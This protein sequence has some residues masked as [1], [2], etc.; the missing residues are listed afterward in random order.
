VCGSK[1]LFA[2][3]TMNQVIYDLCARIHA[4]HLIVRSTLRASK[5]LIVVHRGADIQI[6]DALQAPFNLSTRNRAE[7][8]LQTAL[9]T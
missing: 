9:L 7:G 4:H 3:L 1:G 6:A 2:N 5:F 8:G